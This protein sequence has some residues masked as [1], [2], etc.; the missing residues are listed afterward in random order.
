MAKE[1]IRR[2]LKRLGIS[3]TCVS[4]VQL[5]TADASARRRLEL[6]GLTSF[7]LPYGTWKLYTG[8]SAGALSNQ[9]SISRLAVVGGHGGTQSSNGGTITLDPRS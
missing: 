3:P 9:V 6:D 4:V 1:T 5:S 8:T 7:A 2:N